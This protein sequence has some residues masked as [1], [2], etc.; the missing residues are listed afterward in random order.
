MN[1]EQSAQGA[2]DQQNRTFGFRRIPRFVEGPNGPQITSAKDM[3]RLVDAANALLSMTAKMGP[4]NKIIITDS[5][6]IIQFK[7]D[8][9]Q[10]QL[11][12]VTAG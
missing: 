3:N 11:S 4:S 5:Q 9:T 6:V 10:S 12:A 7:D 1:P 2:L 8:N